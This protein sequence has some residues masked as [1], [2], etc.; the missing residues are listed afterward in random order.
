MHHK[1]KNYLFEWM[2]RITI[3]NDTCIVCRRN[4]I[5]F[6]FSSFATPY[7]RSP[8][9]YSLT[10]TLSISNKNL[11]F[12]SPKLAYFRNGWYC[13]CLRQKTPSPVLNFPPQL[14]LHPSLSSLHA[15][16]PRCHSSSS[17][18][19]YSL[20]THRH[21]RSLR[22]LVGDLSQIRLHSVSALRSL[23]PTLVSIA[24]PSYLICFMT[25]VTQHE[26]LPL[27]F[28]HFVLQNWR[29]IW[30]PIILKSQNFTNKW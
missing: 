27:D 14:N 11:G 18:T 17:V 4:Y 20:T 2:T 25:F 7:F 1:L 3:N 8:L 15:R 13:V 12:K 26:T 29:N 5:T 28:P 9:L 24:F 16:F 10:Q 21:S 30:I 19:H 22:P 6:S 23:T